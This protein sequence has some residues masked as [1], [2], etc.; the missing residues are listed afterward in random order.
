M[1]KYRYYYAWKNNEKRR[2]LYL[3]RLRVVRRGKMN[4]V[5]VEFEGGGREIIS[6]NAIR[7]SKV[8]ESKG[9]KSKE[10]NF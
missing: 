5:E 10:R 1:V 9:R 2:R 6:G 3:K 8:E 7:K 4:S